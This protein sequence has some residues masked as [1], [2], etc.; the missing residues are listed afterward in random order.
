MM[1]MTILRNKLDGAAKREYYLKNR[2]IE[3]ESLL[4]T[5]G[6]TDSVPC[7]LSFRNWDSDDENV[8]G[9]T[10]NISDRK[11]PNLDIFLC[12]NN[13]GSTQSLSA[14]NSTHTFPLTS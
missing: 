4:R 1:K 5:R 3:R 7:V 2:I 8:E 12:P 14:P 6:F 10:L 11:Y 13:F 9:D